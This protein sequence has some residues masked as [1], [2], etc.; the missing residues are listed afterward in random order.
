M[1][2]DYDDII[3]KLSLDESSEV[4]RQQSLHDKHSVTVIGRNYPVRQV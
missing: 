4:A 2:S 1:L 3:E